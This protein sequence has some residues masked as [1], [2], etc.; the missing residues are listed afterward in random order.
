MAITMSPQEITAAI[1]AKFPEAVL[2]AKLEGVIDPFLKIAPAA[3]LE[4][5]RFLH[6][7]PELSFDYL[8]CLSG[9]DNGKGMLGV[10]YHLASMEKKHKIVLKVEV[11]VATPAVPSVESIWRAANWHER[12]AFDMIGI[13]FTGHPDLR[14]ILLPD[15]WEGHPLRKDYKVPEYYQGMKVPY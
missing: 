11:P 5:S 14:R 13:T 4:V 2:D 8:M 6:E 15:D 7:S 10:V 9:M 1:K 3:I 12:E